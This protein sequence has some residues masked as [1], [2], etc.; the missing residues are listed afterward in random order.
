[1]STT[2]AGAF[3]AKVEEYMERL[4]MQQNELAKKVRLSPSHLSRIVKGTRKPPRVGTVRRV[5]KAL[6]LTPSEADELVQLAGLSPLVL[7]KNN[8]KE[9]KDVKGA[10]RSKDAGGKDPD[11]ERP[12]DVV[13]GAL[14]S[15]IGHGRG[16]ESEPQANSTP[17]HSTAQ[18]TSSSRTLYDSPLSPSPQIILM[19]RLAVLEKKLA[20]ADKNLHEAKEELR[21]LR[22]LAADMQNSE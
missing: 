10:T 7:Q 20:S 6:L 13:R 9:K 2:T 21:G 12:T 5:I 22:A 8:S 14:G 11:G 15:G 1:M 17:L 19:R 4:G 16:L 18:K 3:G